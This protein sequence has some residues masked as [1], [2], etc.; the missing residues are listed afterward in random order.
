[1][2]FLIGVA[3]CQRVLHILSLFIEDFV[4]HG[5]SKFRVVDPSIRHKLIS[6]WVLLQLHRAVVTIQHKDLWIDTVK[7]QE[8]LEW[9]VLEIV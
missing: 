5:I 8:I 9:H 2:E 6:R 1:M 4:S 7:D 3:P